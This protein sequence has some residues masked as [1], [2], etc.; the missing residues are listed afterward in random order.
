VIEQ[1]LI[2]LVRQYEVLAVVLGA[3]IEE[4]LVPIP[5]P[6]IPMAAGSIMIE[7][8]HLLPAALKALVIIAF[9]ASVASVVSS[10]FVYSIAYFGGEPAVKRFGKYLDLNWNEVQEME[11]YFGE[12]NQ[13]YLVAGFRAIPIVP[14]SLVSGAAGVFQ[15]E[16][17]Q[18]GLWTFI[19]MM[20]RNFFLAMA[21]WA[22]K[23]RIVEVASRISTLSEMVA[24][25]VTFTVAGYLLYRKANHVYRRMLFD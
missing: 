10:Y 7:T 1:Q 4:I 9:P 11:R 14:L 22:L 18:Y 21:G 5:S 2:E 6:I 24:V 8:P 19:G 15:M 25:T 16:W 12:E 3:L 13:K 20:P 17:K 23:D